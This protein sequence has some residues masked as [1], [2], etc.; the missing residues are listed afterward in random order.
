MHQKI[1]LLLCTLA[2]GSSTLLPST[3]EAKKPNKVK[4]ETTTTT[5]TTTTTSTSIQSLTLTSVQRTQI[6]EIIRGTSTSS[7]GWLKQQDTNHG[8]SI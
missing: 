6:L 5:T 7:T 3:V 4:P 8:T 1:A 2:L